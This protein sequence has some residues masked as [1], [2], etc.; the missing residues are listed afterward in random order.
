MR[1][2]IQKSITTIQITSVEIVWNE[3]VEPDHE[4]PNDVLTLIPA[5]TKNEVASIS[6]KS[7]PALPVSTKTNDNADEDNPNGLTPDADSNQSLNTIQTFQ[8]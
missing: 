3:E 1:R 5:T 6:S 4:Y 8:E 2:V 7:Q